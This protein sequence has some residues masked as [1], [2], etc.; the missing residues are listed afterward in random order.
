LIGSH[1]PAK[2]NQSKRAEKNLGPTRIHIRLFLSPGR[3]IQHRIGLVIITTC[4]KP[5]LL[6]TTILRT[7]CL[8]RIRRRSSFVN[9]DAWS[10]TSSGCDIFFEVFIIH[11]ICICILFIVSLSSFRCVGICIVNTLRLTLHYKSRGL[12]FHTY[13]VARC[14][15]GFSA[16]N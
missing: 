8:L 6:L 11:H 13:R 15:R 9:V 7:F 14:W 12:L 5:S 16:R 1:L 10:R 2:K 3:H 4:N